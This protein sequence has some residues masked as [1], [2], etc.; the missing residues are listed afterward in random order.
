MNAS[1][2]SGSTC[3]P[4]RLWSWR[5]TGDLVHAL[6]SFDQ[7]SIEYPRQA[8][9]LNN[10]LE[11]YASRHH[12]EKTAEGQRLLQLHRSRGFQEGDAFD[13]YSRMVMPKLALKWCM[14]CAASE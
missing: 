2:T 11:V 1:T 13:R 10:M 5:A 7:S 6:V 12:L 3:P 8:A 9:T 14:S 4:G